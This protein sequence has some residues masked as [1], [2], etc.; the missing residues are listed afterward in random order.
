MQFNYFLSVIGI[1]LHQA[2]VFWLYLELRNKEI[3]RNDGQ[4]ER[5][6]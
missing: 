5:S 1:C 4:H 2:I 6:I 3:E